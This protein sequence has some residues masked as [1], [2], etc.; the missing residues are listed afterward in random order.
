MVL[1]DC[2]C[3]KYQRAQRRAAYSLMLLCVPSEH[4]V[5]F[6]VFTCTLACGPLYFCVLLRSLF[7][8]VF[9]CVLLFGV[10]AHALP[11]SFIFPCIPSRSLMFSCVPSCSLMLNIFLLVTCVPRFSLCSLAC[12]P[13]HICSSFPAFSFFMFS[14]FFIVLC[15]QCFLMFPSVSLC[16]QCSLTFLSVPL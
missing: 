1:I 14:C 5:C 13:S 10:F 15:S 8:L 7:F 3:Q 12:H 4:R 9:L 11:C 6:V 2:I 16:S